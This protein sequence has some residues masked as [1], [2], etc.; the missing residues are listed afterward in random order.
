MNPVTND[1]ES[2]YTKRH[3]WILSNEGE[4]FSGN[5]HCIRTIHNY[6][7]RRGCSYGSG[8]FSGIFS[9]KTLVYS[10][11]RFVIICPTHNH[12]SLN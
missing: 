9:Q 6:W 2:G 11:A 1:A 4:N 12:I 10:L 3:L 5:F 7:N 8:N